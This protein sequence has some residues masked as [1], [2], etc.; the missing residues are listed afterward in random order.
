MATRFFR[1]ASVA[2]FLAAAALVSGCGSDSSTDPQLLA[3]NWLGSLSISYRAGSGP[4]SGTV[5]LSLVQEGDF[6]AGAAVWEPIGST[7][8]LSGPIDGANVRLRLS[9]SCAP[10]PPSPPNNSRTEVTVI[11]GTLSGNTLT[12]TGASGYACPDVN[13]TLEVSWA[14]GSVTRSPDGAPL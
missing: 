6:V 5:A 13:Q 11:T 14:T 9:F 10:P 2:A 4:S 7:Q 3:G 1:A 8:S 12:F